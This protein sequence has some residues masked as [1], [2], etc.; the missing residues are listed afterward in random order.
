[1]TRHAVLGE[2]GFQTLLLGT[3]SCQSPSPPSSATQK[4]RFSVPSPDIRNQVR[5]RSQFKES[6]LIWDIVPEQGEKRLL[7]A[8]WLS[9]LRR[10]EGK[11][12]QAAMVD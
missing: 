10:A 3:A 8:V 5:K 4:Y 11:P 9:D 6:Q 2:P 7:Q 12:A 1:M